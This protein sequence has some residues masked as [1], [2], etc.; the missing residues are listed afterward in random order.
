MPAGKKK[1]VLNLL[2][3]NFLKNW[4]FCALRNH[5]AIKYKDYLEITGIMGAINNST[6]AHKKL[7]LQTGEI[8]IPGDAATYFA[9]ICL[10]DGPIF[11][12]I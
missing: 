1:M 3:C 9:W 5:I 7:W 2:F 6:F 12:G 4:F 10:K 8:N 11:I